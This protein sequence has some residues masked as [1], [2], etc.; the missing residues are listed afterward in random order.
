[1]RKTISN[2]DI[3]VALI[4]S[5]TIREAAAILNIRE[6]TLYS[7][8]KDESF[9]VE[10]RAARADLVKTASMKLQNRLSEAIDI[11]CQ[12]MKDESVPPQVRLSAAESIIKRSIS[13]M[14]TIDLTERVEELESV[15]GIYD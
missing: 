2:E 7:R 9:K 4:S 8:M 11:Q 6:K 12:L 15:T 3:I 14:E 1:M 5:S 10:Y 13:L